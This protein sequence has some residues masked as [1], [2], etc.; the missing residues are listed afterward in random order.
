MPTPL[1]LIA[2]A[3][4]LG[5]AAAS[6]AS[7]VELR[8]RLPADGG[9]RYVTVQTTTV[10]LP[11][12][13]EQTT[14]FE[15]VTHTRPA[16]PA[17]DGGVRLRHEVATLKWTQENRF[18]VLTWDSEAPGAQGDPLAGPMA[19][20]VG[21]SF[22]SSHAADGTRLSSGTSIGPDLDAALEIYPEES[23]GMARS[24]LMDLLNDAMLA[25]LAPELFLPALPNAPPS[26]GDRWEWRAGGVEGWLRLLAVEGEGAS[27]LAVLEG[28]ERLGEGGLDALVDRAPTRIQI[29]FSVTE[30]LVVSAER[31]AQVVVESEAGVVRGTSRL[32][33]RRLP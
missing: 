6:S 1:A 5:S 18:G 11:G 23:R 21:V 12:V 27:Q 9:V 17:P 15:A 7:E 4:V 19:A 29:R 31:N 25:A 22:A 2:L 32:E 26:P 28:E 13:G 8:N 30:G 20:L 3:A 14:R 24:L 10:T 16:P 33:L